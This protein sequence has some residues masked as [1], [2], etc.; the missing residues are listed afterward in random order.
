MHNSQLSAVKLPRSLKLKIGGVGT[1]DFRI[2]QGFR[3]QLTPEKRGDIRTLTELI[4]EDVVYFFKIYYVLDGITELF[5][6]KRPSGPVGSGFRF[7]KNDA[8]V[9]LHQSPQTDAGIGI[10]KSAGSLQIIKIF[11]IKTAESVFS[12]QPGDDFHIL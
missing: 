9:L 10:N 4:V 2:A 11:R 5:I 12:C 1:S 6:R 3:L 7:I 8:E